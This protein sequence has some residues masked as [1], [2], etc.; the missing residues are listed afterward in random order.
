MTKLK[1]ETGVPLPIKDA[2]NKEFPFEQMKVGDSIFDPCGKKAEGSRMVTAGRKWFQMNPG[3]CTARTV[4]GG[5]R[6][7]RIE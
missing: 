3:R 2:P 1:I 5:A 6:L 7:W 4:E